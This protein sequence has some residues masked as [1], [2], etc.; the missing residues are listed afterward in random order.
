MATALPQVEES[1]EEGGEAANPLL[2]G[3]SHLGVSKRETKSERWFSNPLF[4]GLDDDDDEEEASH[5]P[6]NKTAVKRK[7]REV[8]TSVK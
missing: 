4:T 8:I 7:R 3:E 5:A 6:S 2:V 1:D